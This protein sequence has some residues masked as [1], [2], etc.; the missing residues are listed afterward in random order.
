MTE[1]D[2][3]PYSERAPATDAPP[4][5]RAAEI[6]SSTSSPA[7]TPAR[8]TVTVLA[9]IAVAGA[10]VLGAFVAYRMAPGSDSYRLGRAFGAL[11]VP[12]L[13]VFVLRLV[14]VRVQHRPWRD[15]YRSGWLPLGTALVLI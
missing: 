12:L 11:F 2:Q 14:V 3:P 4:T 5:A 7:P 6:D 8:R 9:W 10:L 13:L 15:A 1:T